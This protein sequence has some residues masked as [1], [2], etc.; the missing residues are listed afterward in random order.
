MTDEKMQ[1]AHVSK[2]FRKLDYEGEEKDRALGL[3]RIPKE[4]CVGEGSGWGRVK[5]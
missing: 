2:S 1:K 5:F 4:F 3:R